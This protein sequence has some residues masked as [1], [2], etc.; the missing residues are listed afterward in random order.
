MS[1]ARVALRKF[2][3]LF[4]RPGEKRRVSRVFCPRAPF[5]A[6]S[7]FVGLVAVGAGLILAACS[8][9][10]QSAP[11]FEGLGTLGGNSSQATGV[12]ADGSVVVGYGPEASTYMRA[13]RWVGGSMTNLG[14]LGGLRSYAYGVSADGNVV[15]GEGQLANAVYHAFRWTLADGMTDLG[16]L[17]GGYSSASGASA[18]GNVVVGY[19]SV[20]ITGETHAFRWVKDGNFGGSNP[21][22]QDLGTL[23]GVNGGANSVSADGSVVVGW[24]ANADSN[25]HAFRW[26]QAGGMVDLGTLG[27]TS[28]WATGV[29]ADGNVVVGYSNYN[30]DSYKWEVFRWVY[31]GTGPSGGTMTGLGFLPGGDRSTAY[32]V[33]ADGKV[34]VGQSNYYGGPLSYQAF[35]WT[36]AEEM[37]SVQDLLDVAGVDTTGWTLTQATGVSADGSV[38]V[39][40]GTGPSGTEAWIARL[41]I[42]SGIITPSEVAR[43]YAGLGALGKTGNA[44]LGNTLSTMSQ[45]AL[46]GMQ[47]CR[48][49]AKSG[50]A[51]ATGAGQDCPRYSVF[52]VAGYD[53]DSAA[54][55]KLGVTMRL[56]EEGLVGGVVIGAD[57]IRTDMYAD[58]KSTMTGG[59]AGAFIARVPES[60]LQWLVGVSGLHISG[61]VDRGYHNGNTLVTS[62]GNTTGNG[63]GAEARLGWTFDQLAAN[64]KL[65]PFASYTFSSIRYDGYTESGGPFPARFDAFT[66]EMQTT[67]LGLD[68][69]YTL[70]DGQWIWGTLA[71]GHRLNGDGP[72]ISGQ[73]IDLFG[74]SVP[75]VTT[76]SDWLEATAGLRHPV[77]ESAAFTASASIT[78]PEHQQESYLFRAGLSQA[79]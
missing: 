11:S 17:G 40:N 28:S 45:Y 13:F 31:T 76:D 78:V 10:A 74:M 9:F 22:M 42:N 24:S 63:Y 73:L 2:F 26:T 46:Q 18:N 48:E 16:T 33:S 7:F 79:F 54:F 19:S 56:D 21:Q 68:T 1:S 53:S 58:G 27:G 6:R 39:G 38:I 35:R 52:A 4:P 15:V 60:G 49:P 70:G 69:R 20:P 71:W 62:R 44:A 29:S 72:E 32:A 64:M 37:Q 41:A 34:V 47:S 30:V 75:G 67:R 77:S 5:G 23:G 12:S 66:D 59:S 14:T 25:F 36:E 51:S 43:S 3:P 61:D 50:R 55:G 57:Y 8:A 65:T